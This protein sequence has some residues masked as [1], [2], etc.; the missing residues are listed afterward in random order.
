MEPDDP[1]NIPMYLIAPDIA[2]VDF[3]SRKINVQSDCEISEKIGEG[4]FAIVS[5][6]IL[7]KEKRIV[8]IK[9][10]KISDQEKSA[11]AVKVL[12]EFRYDIFPRTMY[13]ISLVY[14]SP[15][16]FT[17]FFG[18]KIFRNFFNFFC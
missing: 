4:S 11:E 14:L 8:A 13:L 2:M 10:L 7:K 9:T 6:G 17:Q 16:N 5:K 1:H 12:N 15:Q 18:R 3:D